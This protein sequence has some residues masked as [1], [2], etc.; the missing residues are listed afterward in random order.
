MNASQPPPT[1]LE[2]S[3][4]TKRALWLGLGIGFLPA[5]MVLGLISA[6]SLGWIDF[7]GASGTATARTLASMACFF[8]TGC[9]AVSS[10]LLFKRFKKGVALAG[11]V[12]LLIVN[13]CVVFFLGCS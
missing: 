1:P 11:A 3:K 13:V 6:L 2:V 12:L 9:A 10:I 7:S 8:S 4:A 5:I